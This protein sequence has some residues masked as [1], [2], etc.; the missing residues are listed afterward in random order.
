MSRNGTEAQKEKYLPKLC[1]GC[2]S[3]WYL[4][5]ILVQFNRYFRRTLW[6]SGYVRGWLR[7]WCC[8][9]EGLLTPSLFAQTLTDHLMHCV[10]IE[11]FRPLLRN[12][13]T[14]TPSM[15]QNFGSQMVMQKHKFLK[16][17][18]TQNFQDPMLT[19]WLSMPRQIPMQQNPSMVWQPS[20]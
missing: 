14:T 16:E 3:F 7:L 12:T 6:C 8:V 1:S 5:F 18:Y 13:K 20:W 19:P 2:T 17:C 10:E 4:W 11:L 15:A 9:Y